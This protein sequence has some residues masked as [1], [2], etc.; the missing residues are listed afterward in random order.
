[1]SE[2]TTTPEQAIRARLNRFHKAAARND[3]PAYAEAWADMNAN[4]TSDIEDLLAE[5][6]RLRGA[7]S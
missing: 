6:D 4:A 3:P 1:M 5:I 2:P 7:L